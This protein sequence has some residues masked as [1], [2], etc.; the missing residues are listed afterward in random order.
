MNIHEHIEK[1][2]VEDGVHLFDKIKLPDNSVLIDFGCGYGEYTISLALSKKHSTVFSV[3][4]D[5]RMLKIVQDKIESHS[6]TNVRLIK[7]DGTLSIAFPDCYSDMILMYDFIHGNT[8]EKLPI[9][10]KFF[11]EARRVLK[12]NGILS[13]APFECEYLRDSSGKRRRYSLGMLI[14][15][16]ESY[17]FRYSESIDGAVHFDYYH[18]PYHWKKLNGEMSFDYLEIGPVMNFYKQK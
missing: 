1:W 7:A 2:Q 6:I 18:S 12:P 4:K 14:S 15:E 8:Q 10:F 17:G 3:D 5:E 11:E 16:I 9:R 13:I